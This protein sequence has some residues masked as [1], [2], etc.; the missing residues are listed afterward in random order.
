MSASKAGMVAQPE[1]SRWCLPGLCQQLFKQQHR[2]TNPM[3]RA[4]DQ[5][6]TRQLSP[7]LHDALVMLI[8]PKMSTAIL[9]ALQGTCRFLGNLLNHEDT[10]RIWGAAT[11]Q[12]LYN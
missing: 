6:L 1:K 4:D 9:G 7:H 8:L 2:R 10:H 5:L 11:L 12:Q 3:Q